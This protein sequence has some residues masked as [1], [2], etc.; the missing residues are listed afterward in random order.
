MKKF[1]WTLNVLTLVAMALALVMTPTA[2]ASAE[3]AAVTD[4]LC[5]GRC[6]FATALATRQGCSSAEDCLQLCSESQ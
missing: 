6:S 5:R 2:P 3:V 4:A 1:N